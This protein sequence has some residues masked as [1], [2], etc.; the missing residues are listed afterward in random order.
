MRID[1]NTIKLF[2]RQML[3]FL[4][5]T[6]IIFIACQLDEKNMIEKGKIHN[7]FLGTITLKDIEIKD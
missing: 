5:T 1:T 4:L 3:V 2:N 7:L 6:V